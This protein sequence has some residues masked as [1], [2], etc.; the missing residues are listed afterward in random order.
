MLLKAGQAEKALVP[1]KKALSLVYGPRKGRAQTVVADIYKALGD[2]E[3]ERLA[4]EQVVA[5]YAALPPGH[6]KP[7]SLALAKKRLAEMTAAAPPK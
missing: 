1:A 2:I 5:I 4:R 3:N 6:A 7:G